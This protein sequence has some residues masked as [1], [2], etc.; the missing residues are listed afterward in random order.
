MN[1]QLVRQS[2]VETAQCCAAACCGRVGLCF[3]LFIVGMVS[4]AFGAVRANED[5]RGINLYLLVLATAPSIFILVYLSRTF[6]TSIDRC[7]VVLT[8]FTTRFGRCRTGTG[9][10][11]HQSSSV[12][13]K[14]R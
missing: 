11:C 4:L 12:H 3:L 13:A 2:S 14:P 10:A 7:Q 1:A 8:F 9:P 5:G 6:G